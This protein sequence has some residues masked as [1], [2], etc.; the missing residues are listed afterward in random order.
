VSALAGRR[1]RWLCAPLAAALLAGSAAS[2][3]S[4][5]V[6][7]TKTGEIAVAGAT[8]LANLDL[9]RTLA[10]VYNDVGVAAAQ[11]SIDV[12]A[13]NRKIIWDGFEQGLA[14]GDILQILALADPQHQSRQY[15]IVDLAHDPI[16]FTGSGC[17]LAAT[18]VSGIVGDLRYAVQGNVLTGDLVVLEA[19]RALLETDGDLSQ[20]VMA[21]MESAR[22]LGGDGRCSC[23]I[24]TPTLCGV[25]PPNF[26]KSAHVAFF[27]LSRK[28]G[29]LGECTSTLGCANGSYF[30]DLKY[31]GGVVKPDPV[32]A[33]ERLY[34][35]W[36]LAQ[37]GR[38]DQVESKVAA[39]ASKLPPNGVSAARVEVEL[40]DLE[41]TP[42][43]DPHGL[44]LACVSQGGPFTT[45]SAI[46]HLG[47][48]R[49]GFS[50]KAGTSAGTDRWQV[51]VEDVR[52]PILL[53]PDVT[54]EVAP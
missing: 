50:L 42:V 28:G 34:E 13:V 12:G 37:A 3:W 43:L 27:V 35:Q 38:P 53:Q 6:V 40:F 52:G 54:L 1:A 44:W 2:T 51:W 45:P 20:R 47:G 17:G 24:G 46:E 49:Y 31:Y 9:Q 19:E 7:D 21:A 41:G 25:P 33:M 48:N 23:G 36:R 32:I 4:I 39:L 18:G 10:V 16:T 11:S 5:V 30:L 15:G 8:C 26:T 22:R 14:P 29:R